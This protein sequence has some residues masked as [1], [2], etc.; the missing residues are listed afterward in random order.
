MLFSGIPF[1]YYFL[2]CVLFLYFLI[3]KSL[4]NGFLLLSS[5]LFYAWGEPKYVLLMVAAIVLFYSFGL[6]IGASRKKWV[7]RLWLT[8]SIVTG[9]VMLGV[10]K[11]ADLPWITG[12]NSPAWAF[13]C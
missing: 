9:C 7:R 12:T 2:P 3:P 11:Y 6:A 8:A 1:L 5:L 10:F 4:K 13:R